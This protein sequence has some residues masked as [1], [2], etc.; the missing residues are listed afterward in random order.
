MRYIVLIRPDLAKA[1]AGGPS[2]QLMA[3]MGALISEM[4]KAGVLLDTA[5]LGPAEEASV[6]QLS[7][8]KVTTVDGPYTEAR[9]FIGGYA[10]LQ[11]ATQEEAAEW[12][13]RFLEIHGDEWEIVAEVRGVFGPE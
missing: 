11:V 4:T 6:L 10:L 1:P 2:E 5:G 3:D 8:G 7:A 12:A 9:E 13:K